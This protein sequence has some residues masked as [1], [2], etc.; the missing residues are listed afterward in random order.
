MSV[1]RCVI[2]HQSFRRDDDMVRRLI[3]LFCPIHIELIIVITPD[4]VC[5][6]LKNVRTIQ[7]FLMIG[8]IRQEP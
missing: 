5:N 8:S 2:A 6:D 1:F 7:F 3:G 4:A